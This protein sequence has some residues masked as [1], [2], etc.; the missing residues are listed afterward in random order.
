MLRQF[1]PNKELWEYCTWTS[2][3]NCAQILSERLSEMLSLVSAAPAPLCRIPRLRSCNEASVCLACRWW[4]G[5]RIWVKWWMNQIEAIIF[6]TDRHTFKTKA[7][8]HWHHISRQYIILGCYLFWNGSDNLCLHL[9]RYMCISLIF[10][11][12]LDWQQI[13]LIVSTRIILQVASA[14]N[15]IWREL[16]W[17]CKNKGDIEGKHTKH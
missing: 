4:Q 9:F 12:C 6:R 3:N 14:R 8:Y 5:Y 13:K 17:E 1:N 16:D 15:D 2:R 7:A 10:H 11:K